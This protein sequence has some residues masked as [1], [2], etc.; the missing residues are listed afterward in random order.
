MAYKLTNELKSYHCD[1]EPVVIKG[2]KFEGDQFLKLYLRTKLQF[3]EEFMCSKVLDCFNRGTRKETI[4]AVLIYTDMCETYIDKSF[5]SRLECL[6][7]RKQ[8]MLK[9]LEFKTYWKIYITGWF[10]LKLEKCKMWWRGGLNTHGT[11]NGFPKSKL[12]FG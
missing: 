7:A 6:I 3:F 5:S 11:K 8:I 10:H 4:Q 2:F 9:Q 12:V 1:M